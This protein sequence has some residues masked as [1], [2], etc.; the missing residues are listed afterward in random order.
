M[1]PEKSL[2][3]KILC[4]LEV[5]AFKDSSRRISMLACSPRHSVPINRGLSLRKKKRRGD[6][7]I[8]FHQSETLPSYLDIAAAGVIVPR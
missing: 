8:V 3:P 7:D 2:L 5:G 4:H 6:V 1:P